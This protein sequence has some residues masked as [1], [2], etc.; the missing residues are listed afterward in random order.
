MS[1]S[2]E[3]IELALKKSAERFEMHWPALREACGCNG[4]LMPVEGIDRD[5]PRRL[6]LVAGIDYFAPC[7]T[8]IMSIGSRV[9]EA[10]HLY[11]ST[12]IR[13]AVKSGAQTEWAKKSL[14]YKNGSM[15]PDLTVQVYVDKSDGLVGYGVVR[16]KEMLDYVNAG[17]AFP[18]Y[19]YTTKPVD[20]GNTLMAIWWLW[21]RREGV[22]V[23]TSGEDRL[24]G[25][26]NPW[27]VSLDEP[28]MRCWHQI[29]CHVGGRLLTSWQDRGW[30]IYD[31]LWT[32]ASGSCSMEECGCEAAYC[33]RFSDS[34]KVAAVSRLPVCQ[35]CSYRL[36]PV[37]VN[38]GIHPGCGDA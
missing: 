21:M 15:I 33:P 19:T 10:P 35:I 16:T 27:H 29:G 18:G 11:A 31:R 36:D 12:T 32:D 14:A 30:P 38:V 1:R 13:L 22:A 2:Q 26:R 6:D 24:R 25:P 4:D 37:L 20:G 34:S 9:Q 23:K 28:C 7:P 3:E 8:G 17:P 5:L